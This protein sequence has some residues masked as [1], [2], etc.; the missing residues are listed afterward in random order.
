MEKKA[1]N[2]YKWD[3][4]F[5]VVGI[6]RLHAWNLEFTPISPSELFNQYIAR[7]AETFDT[8]FNERGK[9]VLIDAILSE[10]L[11]R[12]KRLKIWKE[13]SLNTDIATGRVE[14]LV[15]ERLDILRRPFLC[16]SEAKKDDFEKGLAQCL[17]EMKACQFLNFEAGYKIDVHGIVTNGSEWHF[18]KLTPEN[19]VFESRP[20]TF[21]YANDLFGALN[22]IFVACERNLK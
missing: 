12:C 11:S 16:V 10:A 2:K 18:Y 22:T 8:R 20:Y 9:E 1:F 13:A 21:S 14:Y 3:E 7:L 17:V 19:M 4:S 15:A 6:D 5:Q